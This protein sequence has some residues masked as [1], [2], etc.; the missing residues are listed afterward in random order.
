MPLI[1]DKPK[2]QWSRKRARAARTAAGLSQA[3]L[4]A[5]IGVKPRYIRA[6][7]AGDRD[8]PRLTL[9]ARWA[10]ACKCPIEALFDPP[11]I[12]LSSV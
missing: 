11:E 7:E 6:L 9:G 10:K 12:L 2:G 3:E 8:E 4:A 5:L 1:T